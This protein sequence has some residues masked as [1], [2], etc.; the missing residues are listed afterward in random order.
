MMQSPKS[1]GLKHVQTLI[2]VRYKY[3]KPWIYDDMFENANMN[4]WCTCIWYE[5]GQM[6]LKSKFK[7]KVK[8]LGKIWG[9]GIGEYFEQLGRMS[10]IQ[11]YSEKGYE[12][13]LLFLSIS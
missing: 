2:I 8:R 6:N 3:H 7:W 5:Y 11:S 4:E 9:Y 10:R 12:C 1:I 13:S